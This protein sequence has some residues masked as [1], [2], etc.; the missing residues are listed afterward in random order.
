LQLHYNISEDALYQPLI[1]VQ[2]D[3]LFNINISLNISKYHFLETFQISSLKDH[4]Q[5]LTNGST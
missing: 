5:N 1:K 2:N 3:N 4:L